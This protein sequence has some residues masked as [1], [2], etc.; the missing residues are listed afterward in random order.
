VDQSRIDFRVSPAPRRSFLHIAIV[1]LAMAA[2]AWGA[3]AFGAVY[4]WAFTPLAAVCAAVG[5]TGLATG[6]AGRPPIGA[7]AAALVVVGLA[8]GF[9]ILPLPS[10]VVERIS[11]AA[12]ALMRPADMP[13]SAQ[14][15]RLTLSIVPEKTVIGLALFASL[16]LF[17]LGSSRVL[18]SVGAYPLAVFILAMGV[19]LSVIGMVQDALTA[20]DVAPLIYG[21]WKPK[22]GRAFGPF[23][24]R[25]H[26]AGW[27]LM[28]LPLGMAAAADAILRTGHAAATDRDGYVPSVSSGDFGRPLLIASASVVM[29]AALLLTRSRSGVVAF[30]AGTVLV[31]VAVLRRQRTVRQRAVILAAFA[32]LVLGSAMWAGVDNAI[33][34][35]FERDPVPSA[36]GGRTGAWKD[37]VAIIRD[38]PLTGAGLNSYG[39][40]M[41]LY[42]SDSRQLHYQEAHNDYL[43]LAAEGGALVGIPVLV[44]IGI[45][46]RDVRRR[47]SEAPKVGTTYWLRVGSVVGLIAIALQSMVEFSLQMPG[48]A[49][50]FAAIAAIA[51]H[52]SPNLRARP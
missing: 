37:A 6:E 20:N 48:N 44:A 7:L 21:F 13:T 24:N 3:F 29:G 8:I 28:A 2:V 4:P 14:P 32:V 10:P 30:A 27:M 46:V 23:V 43:Q 5:I 40:A 18:S 26:F 9:Q 39:S 25:N 45:F 1:S 19:L 47:F 15:T 16:A 12:D 52:R 34:K 17:L 22:G 41:T 33:G 49:A 38:F 35:F 11:P 51:L 31:A 42:Q 50:M 36:V